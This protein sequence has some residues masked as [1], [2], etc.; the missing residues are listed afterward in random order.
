MKDKKISSGAATIVSAA[1]TDG[2]IKYTNDKVKNPKLLA[3]HDYYGVAGKY[4]KFNADYDDWFYFVEDTA[5]PEL[6]RQISRPPNKYV[7]PNQPSSRSVGA[8]SYDQV[9]GS[10][11]SRYNNKSTFL[12]KLRKINMWKDKCGGGE[13]R[14][15][16]RIRFSKVLDMIPN[17]SINK[18]NSIPNI[19][20]KE[21]V[22]DSATSLKYF[23]LI[24]FQSL[25]I[26][27]PQ[28]PRPQWIHIATD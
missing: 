18:P 21:K 10:A 20:V 2:T 15:E 22:S 23:E 19:D 3:D 17:D 4:K 24:L 1:V 6:H 14:T 9:D 16:P 27:V 12:D 5:W 11:A 8:R 7:Y 28:R 13:C 25:G 26:R